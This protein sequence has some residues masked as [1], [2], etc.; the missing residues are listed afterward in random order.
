MRKPAPTEEQLTD[1]V[2][3][4]LRQPM[5]DRA[6]ATRLR[7]LA[8]ASERISF[9]SGQ[10]V[11]REHDLFDGAYVVLSGSAEVLVNPPSGEV[12]VATIERN[13]MIGAT[14]ILRGVLLSND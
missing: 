6:A 1:E 12:K 10:T 7:A 4:L 3:V 8:L 14:E 5:C 13:T 11:L 2:D 9:E